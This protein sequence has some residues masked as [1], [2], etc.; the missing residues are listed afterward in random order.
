MV[1]HTQE[2]DLW[3]F[4]QPGQSKFQDSQGCTESDSEARVDGEEMAIDRKSV[5]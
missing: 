3:F 4:S 5:V 1:M 2:A